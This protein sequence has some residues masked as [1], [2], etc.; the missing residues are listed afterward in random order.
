[1]I[2]RQ[3]LDPDSSTYCYVVGCKTSKEIAIVDSV[4]EQLPT[5]LNAI[6]SQGW[7]VRYLVETHIHA[8]HITASGLLKEK[9]PLAEVVMGDKSELKVPFKGVSEGNLLTLG[10]VQIEIMCTPGHTTESLSLLINGERLLTGDAL[11]IGACGRT[12]FQ[13][14]SNEEQF[15]TLQK[16]AKLPPDILVF[17]GHDYKGRTVSTIREELLTNKTLQCK[18]VEELAAEVR[19]WNLQQP[20]RIHEAVPANLNCGL[21]L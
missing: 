2:F 4:K 6:E 16:F 8:D 15:L 5:Y 13:K 9:F 10:S 12:D 18:N 21:V 7:K 1:M 11:L 20:K 3:Y 14:G 19:S 17:P